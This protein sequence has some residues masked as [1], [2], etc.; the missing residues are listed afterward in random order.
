MILDMTLWSH[1]V[2]PFYPTIKLKV[3]RHTN[4]EL[5]YDNDILNGKLQLLD[6][7]CEFLHF[8]ASEISHSFSQKHNNK[9][10]LER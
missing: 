10:K 5:K 8:H 2:G 1:V 7:F 6:L 9:E 3:W 4:H